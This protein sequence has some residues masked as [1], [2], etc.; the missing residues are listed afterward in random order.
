MIKQT[1]LPLE[2]SIEVKLR[3]NLVNLKNLRFYSTQKIILLLYLPD[4][5]EP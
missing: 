1:E 5:Y 4:L 2:L 3:V